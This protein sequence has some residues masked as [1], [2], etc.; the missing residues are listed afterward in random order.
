VARVWPIR[1]LNLALNVRNEAGYLVCRDMAATEA[2]EAKRQREGFGIDV[3]GLG[4]QMA[5]LHL[6]HQR[7]DAMKE[8]WRLLMFPVRV[9]DAIR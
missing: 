7:C 4:A 5:C 6:S 3:Q 1:K 2:G 8:N 9:R